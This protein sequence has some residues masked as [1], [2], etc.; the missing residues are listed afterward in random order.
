VQV[1]KGAHTFN[2]A[3][4][5]AAFRAGVRSDNGLVEPFLAL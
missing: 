5:K 2:W 1:Q 3:R 4:L